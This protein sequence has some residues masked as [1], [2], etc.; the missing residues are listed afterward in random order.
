MPGDDAYK[1]TYTKNI[2][3]R[4]LFLS[5][6]EIYKGIYELVDAFKIL[7]QKYLNIE[8]NIAGFGSEISN[9][10]T[11]IDNNNIRNVN[12]HGY[13]LGHSKFNLISNSDVFVLPSYSEGMPNALLESMM[14]G[15]PVVTTKVGAIND[16]FEEDKMGFFIEIKDPKSIV[17]SVEKVMI[18]NKK[19]EIGIFNK[20]F[21][22]DN[23]STKHIIKKFISA[24]EI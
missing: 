11:Y 4:I 24:T 3:F 5:R 17:K 14:V 6:I 15:I 12:F 16:F 7:S 23:F 10:K 18:H 22:Y 13:L 19:N 9:I 2:N 21:A 20:K 1:Y 8:L